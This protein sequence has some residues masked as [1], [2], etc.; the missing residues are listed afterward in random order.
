[1]DIETYLEQNSQNL[2]Q[3]ISKLVWLD[4]PLIRQNSMQNDKFIFETMDQDPQLIYVHQGA[5][6]KELGEEEVPFFEP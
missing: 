6:V 2:L 5:L 1:M 3:K 4:D